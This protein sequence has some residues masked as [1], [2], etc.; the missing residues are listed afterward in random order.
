MAADPP[1]AAPG[2]P[3]DTSE[4]T[5]IPAL[6]KQLLTDGEMLARAELRL[7]QA[8]A[9]SQVRAAI[10]GLVAILVGA[11]F[12][13]ASL[14]TLLAALIGWLTPALGAGNAALVVTLGTAALGGIAVAV[15]S[16]Q[17]GKRA[18]VPPLRQLRALPAQQPHA[19]EPKPALSTEVK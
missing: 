18:N 15:G 11:I 5:P 19:S 10:P 16:N 4:K 17:L 7:A 2:L 1:S 13:L 14:F 8:Q 9:T 6:F 3:G 12:L